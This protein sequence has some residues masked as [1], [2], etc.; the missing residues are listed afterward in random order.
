MPIKVSAYTVFCPHCHWKQTWKPSSDCLPQ[1]AKPEHCP[2]CNHGGVQSR[3][4][5][6][7]EL[8][9]NSKRC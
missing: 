2:C 4:P 7:L 6:L 5:T 9:F 3:T 8:L 1:V